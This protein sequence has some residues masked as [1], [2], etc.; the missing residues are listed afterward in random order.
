[1]QPW[2]RLEKQLVYEYFSKDLTYKEISDNLKSSGYHRS[3][4]AVRKFLTKFPKNKTKK[5]TIRVHE[6]ALPEIFED[7]YH[8]TINELMV[9]R[10][11][12]FKTTTE[13][14]IKIG[15]PINAGIKVLTFSDFH[16]PFVNRHVLEHGIT[17]HSDADVLVINGDL[18]D[19]YLVS[20]W[21]KS[22]AVL[23]QWEYQL[24]LE[25]IKFFSEVFPQVILVSGNHDH[26]TQ[27]YFSTR[28]DPAVS[29]LTD[30]DM[31]QRLA[32]G[33]DFT[34]YGDFERVHDFR[35]VTYDNGLLNWY[36][37]LGKSLFVHPLKGYSTEPCATTLK[38]AK[39]FI[40]R[41]DWQCLVMAHTH[42]QTRSFYKDRLLIE[43]GCACIP[44][45]Y[46]AQ[47][48][49]NMDSQIFGYATIYMDRLGNVDYDKTRTTYIGTGSPIKTSD[50]LM[51]F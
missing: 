39:H 17:H 43:Q 8:S 10:D 15:N 24:A 6:K 34:E 46:E 16:L 14:F 41:E 30:P 12:L 21:P 47:G 42:R 49:M 27:K 40:E 25:W 33:Y 51:Y 13:Q 29:F 19:A 18:F 36:T 11:K 44:M 32:Q 26:R 35:N 48:H 7:K 1:M 22:K 45:E 31:L 2:E 23:L 37:L 38:A 50:P 3:A 5:T 28:I 4:E 9:L 20:K